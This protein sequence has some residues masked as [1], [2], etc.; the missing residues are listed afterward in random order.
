MRMIHTLAVVAI[1]AATP[2]GMAPL[3]AQYLQA[4]MFNSP[5]GWVSIHSPEGSEWFEMRAFDGDADP[6]CNTRP[7]R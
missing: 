7:A 1:L 2:A 5:D 4:A 6:R 3:P